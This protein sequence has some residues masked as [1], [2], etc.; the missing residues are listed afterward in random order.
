MTTALFSA[1]Q[2][3]IGVLAPGKSC[4]VTVTITPVSAG[5]FADS[6]TVDSNASNGLTQSV[7]VTGVVPIHK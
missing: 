1:S 3:C 2:N 7:A 5:T 6:L 4:K